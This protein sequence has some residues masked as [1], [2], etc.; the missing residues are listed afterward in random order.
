MHIMRCLFMGINLQDSGVLIVAHLL[1]QLI[2]NGWCS[3][4]VG[5]CYARALWL[6]IFIVSKNNAL[7]GHSKVITMIITPS[8]ELTISINLS[9]NCCTNRGQ[10]DHLGYTMC[11]PHLSC[12]FQ[13]NLEQAFYSTFSWLCNFGPLIKFLGFCSSIWLASFNLSV[14]VRQFLT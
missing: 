3:Q 8:S 2:M 14:V 12:F 10:K 4:L 1:L 6:I 5:K 13:H 11:M 7:M 9:S